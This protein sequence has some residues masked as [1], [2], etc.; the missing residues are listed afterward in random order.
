MKVRQA[1]PLRARASRDTLEWHSGRRQHHA[2]WHRL[3]PGRRQPR[4]PRQYPHRRA[5]QAAPRPPVLA[6][7]R[8]PG[9]RGP[10]RLAGRPAST[11][12][13]AGSAG[14]T[15][16]AGHVHLR[17][18]GHV[19]AVRDRRACGEC[20]CPVITHHPSACWKE[21]G[22]GADCQTRAWCHRSSQAA[23]ALALAHA[24]L[25]PTRRA[26]SQR[27]PVCE[28]LSRCACLNFGAALQEPLHVTQTVPRNQL[29]GRRPG[30]THSQRP[31]CLQPRRRSGAAAALSAASAY[32]AAP[33]SSSAPGS[34]HKSCA[35]EQA[36][37]V[38][39]TYTKIARSASESKRQPGA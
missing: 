1:G 36:H 5:R 16:S 32:C 39:R 6:P 37:Q 25:L 26:E 3:Q 8:R 17:T 34:A 24:H 23:A 13:A 14:C 22:G 19:Q 18:L 28:L 27:S 29:A 12:G 15:C 33:G 30:L 21:C 4:Q 11:C 7:L 38:R 31:S 10:R 20:S 9:R 35:S 2:R